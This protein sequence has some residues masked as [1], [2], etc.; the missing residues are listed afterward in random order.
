MNRL[1]SQVAVMSPIASIIKIK[2]TARKGNTIGP[3]M[4]R[5]NV[6]IQ[7]NVAVGAS[8]IGVLSK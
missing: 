8:L 1:T 3:D 4:A 2:N 7:I 6:F 5:G